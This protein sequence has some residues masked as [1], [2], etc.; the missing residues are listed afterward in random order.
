[1]KLKFEQ[2]DKA[3]W[4]VLNG[5]KLVGYVAKREFETGIFWFFNPLQPIYR[6]NDLE[7]ILEFMKKLE[8]EL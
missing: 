5:T 1:M 4:S 8:E 7:Q 6:T 3:Q 2:I